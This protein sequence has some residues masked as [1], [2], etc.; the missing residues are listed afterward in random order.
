MF[1]RSKQIFFS[2]LTAITFVSYIIPRCLLARNFTSN[3]SFLADLFHEM[4]LNISYK[5]FTCL[6]Q[7]KNVLNKELLKI[8]IGVIDAQLFKAKGKKTDIKTIITSI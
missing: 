4:F 6:F 7:F 3:S 5:I 8:F 2:G 1:V